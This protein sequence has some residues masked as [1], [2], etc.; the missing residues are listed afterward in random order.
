MSFLIETIFAIIILV[1]ST[2]LNTAWSKPEKS[3]LAFAVSVDQIL[4]KL[5]FFA[6]NASISLYD[7]S[8]LELKG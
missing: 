2:G 1:N 4:V 7:I 5:A 3:V 8:R 6:R